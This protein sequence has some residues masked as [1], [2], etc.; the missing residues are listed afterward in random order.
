MRHIS[1]IVFLVMFLCSSCGNHS[2]STDVEVREGCYLFKDDKNQVS[3]NIAIHDKIV[4]GNLNYNLFEK[5]KNSGTLKGKFYGDTLIADYTFESEG[6]SSVREVAFLYNK[7]SFTEGYG[8]MTEQ[9]GKM[10][11]KDRTKLTFQISM[12]LKK[13]NCN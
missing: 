7:N 2:Q 11:F 4:D 5:D 10:I 9:E 8:E 13:G 6:I 3:M 12:L 1:S